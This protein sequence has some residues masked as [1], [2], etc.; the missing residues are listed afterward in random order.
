MEYFVPVLFA[1]A[2]ILGPW[3]FVVSLSD[4]LKRLQRRVDALEFNRVSSSTAA[5][6]QAPPPV[7]A[8]QIP[9]PPIPY[10]PIVKPPKAPG[11]TNAEWEMLIGGKLLNRIGS[12][13][14]VLAMVFF[15]KYAFDNDLIPPIGRVGIGF[16]AGAALIYAA[17]RWMKKGLAGFAQGIAS[18]AITILYLSAYATY[19]FYD[20]LPQPI[21]FLLMVGVTCLAVWRAIA[22]NS[23]IVA[24]MA[25]LGGFTTPGWL[26]TG[27]MNTVGLFT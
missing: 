24:I 7:V 1:L 2:L 25:A 4:R 17:H 3:F 13:A 23:L 12:V 19:G 9:Q 11:R 21:A 22:H 26:S 15:L 16:A 8:A 20:I 14:I 5:P 6:T 18:T 27:E 10:P